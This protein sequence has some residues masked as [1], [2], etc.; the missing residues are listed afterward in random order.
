MACE[1][2][3]RNRIWIKEQLDNARERTRQL[4]ERLSTSND[5]DS[6]TEQHTNRE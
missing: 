1:S 2:C 3:E 5:Q 4:L 6:R